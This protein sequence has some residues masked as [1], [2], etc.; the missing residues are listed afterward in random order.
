MQIFFLFVVE[1]INSK[2]SFTFNSRIY[3]HFGIYNS[4][5]ILSLYLSSRKEEFILILWNIFLRNHFFSPEFQLY[6]HILRPKR[7]LY[8]TNITSINSWFHNF[9]SHSHTKI[10]IHQFLFLLD[11]L[12]IKPRLATLLMKLIVKLIPPFNH[13]RRLTFNNPLEANLYKYNSC[14]T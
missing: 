12:S 11:F 14:L 5:L 8:I 13:D 6:H 3:S 7:K 1:D 4:F 9:S 2:I 10:T